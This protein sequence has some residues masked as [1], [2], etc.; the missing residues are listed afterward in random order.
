MAR[1]RMRGRIWVVGALA[2]AAAG[3]AGCSSPRPAASAAAGGAAPAAAGPCAAVEVLAARGTGEPQSGSLIMGSLPR[4]IAQRTG[5][6]V[7]QVRYPASVDYINGPNQ[8]AD[9]ALARLRAQAAACPDQRFVLA[10]YSEGA[11]VMTTL[12]ARLPAAIE[13]RVVAAVLYGNPYYKS[14]SPSATGSARGQANGLVPGIGVPAA[15]AGR[16]RDYCN[17]GDPVCGAG[18]NVAAHLSYSQYN[19]EAVDFAVGRVQQE[20]G[21]APAP[22]ATPS[23]QAGPAA[24]SGSGATGAGGAPRSVVA[25]V[26]TPAYT[27]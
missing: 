6:Q 23:T 4:D 21:R 17:T 11:M 1:D 19:G 18:S 15:F 27:G 26:A 5:G 20:R 12:M 10:G 7:Y 24:G 9:D 8:G 3:A 16:T 22:G 2:V 25:V 13:P 14:S